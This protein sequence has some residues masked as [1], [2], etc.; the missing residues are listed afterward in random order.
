M[1]IR[2]VS[3]DQRPCFRILSRSVLFAQGPFQRVGAVCKYRCPLIYVGG[4]GLSIHRHIAVGVFRQI[5]QGAGVCDG[6]VSWAAVSVGNGRSPTL[7]YLCVIGG[8][9][10]SIIAAAFVILRGNVA[11]IVSRNV[12]GGRIRHMLFFENLQTKILA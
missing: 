10:F 9:W 8:P 7:R 1:Y 2:N 3:D 5:V 12:P 11:V 4:S 6:C